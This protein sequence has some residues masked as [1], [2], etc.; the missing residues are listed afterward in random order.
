[1]YFEKYSFDATTNSEA[2]TTPNG[3]VTYL[4]QELLWT[5][6]F[7]KYDLA[8]L[9]LCASKDNVK[10]DECST[11]NELSYANYSLRCIAAIIFIL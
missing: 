3:L 2:L 5:S 4:F 7:A 1:L 9:Y 10:W 11:A 8:N 6:F